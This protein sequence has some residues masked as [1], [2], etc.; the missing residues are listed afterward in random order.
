LQSHTSSPAVASYIPATA[1]SGY[2]PF[3]LK[4]AHLDEWQV[5]GGELYQQTWSGVGQ[6]CFVPV[7]EK[8]RVAAFR[9]AFK[10]V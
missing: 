10:E 9:I 3:Q 7:D 2:V 6:T 8:S 5:L 4:T 1:A